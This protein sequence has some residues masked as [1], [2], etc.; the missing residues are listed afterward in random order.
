M[1]PR[2]T[3]VNISENRR[4]ISRPLRFNQVS[5]GPFNKGGIVKGPT[6]NKEGAEIEYGFPGYEP[7]FV[8]KRNNAYAPSWP[9]PWEFSGHLHSLD[10]CLYP[11]GFYEAQNPMRMWPDPFKCGT[12]PNAWN[13]YQ[14]LS[15]YDRLRPMDGPVALGVN[16]SAQLSNL[17][18][19]TRY[20]RPGHFPFSSP[21]AGRDREA[22]WHADGTKRSSL[23][24][25][26]ATAPIGIPGAKW[27][28]AEERSMTQV[29]YNHRI[30]GGTGRPVQQDKR[31][32]QEFMRKPECKPASDTP[33]T[34]FKR[35]SPQDCR[36]GSPDTENS[37]ATVEPKMK[38]QWLFDAAEKAKEMATTEA[39]MKY[40]TQSRAAHWSKCDGEF[41]FLR[42]GPSLHATELPWSLRSV[43]RHH[44]AKSF[45]GP[46]QCVPATS[47]A[48][49]PKKR[50]ANNTSEDPWAFTD[51]EDDDEMLFCQ[52]EL[53]KRKNSRYFQRTR[54]LYD[55]HIV[56][57]ICVPNGKIVVEDPLGANYYTFDSKEGNGY[58]LFSKGAGHSN[59]DKKRTESPIAE[60]PVETGMDISTEAKDVFSE[61]VVPPTVNLDNDASEHCLDLKLSTKETENE[62]DAKGIVTSESTE[63][64]VMRPVCDVWASFLHIRLGTLYNLTHREVVMA[65]ERFR[66]SFDHDLCYFYVPISMECYGV[67][68]S[69]DDALSQRTTWRVQGKEKRDTLKGT[70]ERYETRAVPST[71][72]DAKRLRMLSRH[73]KMFAHKLI[74][75][76]NFNRVEPIMPV[77]AVAGM[78]SGANVPPYNW[79]RVAEFLQPTPC[80]ELHANARTTTLLNGQIR[81][82]IRE[83]SPLLD[84]EVF[85][86]VWGG[87][88]ALE[89]AV[90]ESQNTMEKNQTEVLEKKDLP[91]C[92]ILA[93]EIRLEHNHL[94]MVD[95]RWSTGWVLGRRI[96]DGCP[97]QDV[98]GPPESQ[99]RY[100]F[101]P[102]LHPPQVT[103]AYAPAGDPR[104]AA[105]ASRLG[106]LFKACEQQRSVLEA[107]ATQRD[108]VVKK[109]PCT[110]T[111]AAATY[112]DHFRN[113]PV[114][115][116]DYLWTGPSLESRV[117]TTGTNSRTSVSTE[118]GNGRYSAASDTAALGPSVLKALLLDDNGSTS[119][120][121]AEIKCATATPQ[122]LAHNETSLNKEDEVLPSSANNRPAEVAAPKEASGVDDALTADEDC[123]ASQLGRTC[124]VVSSEV[125]H[126]LSALKKDE[127]YNVPRTTVACK[128]FL[129]GGCAREQK[130]HFLHPLDP[131]LECKVDVRHVI[132][133]HPKFF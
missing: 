131:S 126:H 10:R 67:Y 106:F 31:V 121:V 57:P 90:S 111:D 73:V 4:F 133:D 60:T 44:T 26:L 48:V 6:V 11:Y 35:K 128:F 99:A 63:L 43:Y 14:M 88:L 80:I 84:Q 66:Q 110:S 85:R 100:I 16:S 101:C 32:L 22:R 70:A 36:P 82:I 89:P 130:C 71:E 118:G 1:E 107:T 72:N 23:Y 123:K 42:N 53:Q 52:Y 29:D 78:L 37:V 34:T 69:T 103:Y 41:N 51:E 115:D 76:L 104:S 132:P 92:R 21:L 12:F 119:N 9:H 25:S 109:G 97:D 19:D 95:P 20:Q 116:M 38:I 54:H 124:T 129:N 40:T 18:Y 81:V 87:H 50:T 30:F 17:M 8:E 113:L 120:G 117:T 64:S 102:R 127:L 93:G 45:N 68:P 59:V 96:A 39:G 2:T 125:F 15:F 61:E 91:S 98:P 3:V 77:P 83:W 65:V 122:R 28:L 75:D 112:R 105:L 27:P 108:L 47:V 55:I 86:K 33:D 5:L 49:E 56:L 114:N 46:G 74:R 13:Q 79:L 94:R 58:M 7:H 62:P 24:R